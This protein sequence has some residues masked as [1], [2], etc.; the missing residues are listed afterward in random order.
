MKRDLEILKYKLDSSSDIELMAI[1]KLKTTTVYYY[2]NY[3]RNLVY[4]ISDNA[5]ECRHFKSA[6]LIP[7]Y[8]EGKLKRMKNA[9]ITVTADFYE[10]ITDDYFI[11]SIKL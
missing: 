6:F 5:Y 2:V 9:D 7:D 3:S 10:D 8:V 1:V 11:T 4:R